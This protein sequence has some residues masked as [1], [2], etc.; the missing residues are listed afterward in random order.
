MFVSKLEAAAVRSNGAGSGALQILP[1][2]SS[3]C[4]GGRV[5]YLRGKGAQ[6]TALMAA[7]MHW[8]MIE[9]LSHLP[10]CTCR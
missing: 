10:G 3:L 9:P 1:D 6:V 2:Q 7:R 5:H 4:S 8:A